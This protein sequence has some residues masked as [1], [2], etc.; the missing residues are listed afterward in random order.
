MH[1]L[2]TITRLNNP[3]TME[4]KQMKYKAEVKVAGDEKWYSN[5]LSFDSHE[6]AEEYAKDLFSR[7]LATTEWR[8][9][10]DEKPSEEK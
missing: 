10:T 1:C 2:S 4:R 5:A 3:K 8:V 6:E 7:W 9:A